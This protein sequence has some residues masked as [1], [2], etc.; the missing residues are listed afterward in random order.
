MSLTIVAANGQPVVGT[1]SPANTI[2]GGAGF[3][4]LV[5]GSNFVSNSVVNFNGAARQTTFVSGTQLSIA[6]L[7]A[8]IANAGTATITV[9]N[10][11]SGSAG[12]GTSNAMSLTILAANGQPV[13]GNLSPAG[14]TAGGAAFI[15]LL[16]GN[17]FTQNSIVTFNG[18]HVPSAFLSSTQVQANI[19]ASAIAAAGSFLVAVANPGENP[20]AVVSFIVNNPVPQENSLSPASGTAGSAA[21]TLKVIGTDFNLSSQ[22]WVNNAPRPTTFVNPTLLQ[23]LLSASDLI[24]GATLQLAVN[25]PGPF[26]GGTTSTLPFTVADYTVALPIP[27]VTVDAG[28][29]AIFNLTVAP[30]NGTFANP[31]LFAVTGLPPSATHSFSPSA[32]VIPGAT[33]QTIILS[34]TTT[35][36]SITSVP[37]LPKFGGPIVMF[38]SLAGFAIAFARFVWAASETAAMRWKRFVPRATVAILLICAASMM[39]CSTGSGASVP[40]ANAATGTPAG[41][42]TITVTA[43]SSGITHSASATINVI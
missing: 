5:N 36:H 26:G 9:T 15:L 34:V 32:T 6:I 14:T 29:T 35:A 20:T 37:L 16:S 21:L 18:N 43:T 41:N 31:V 23:T 30:S 40:Q 27:S 1:L 22:I 10:P 33:S 25:N 17:G 42:Y 38:L 12:G 28:Q 2:A 19:P 7:P 3:T 4:L 24:Q 13:V 39:A 8:D 11:A